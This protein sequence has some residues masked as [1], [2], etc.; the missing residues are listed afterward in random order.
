MQKFEK[1][2]EIVTPTLEDMGY[3]LVR[4]TLGGREA[5]KV[6]QI[7][8]ER[9]DMVPMTVDDCA[10]ISRNLS[11]ILDVED[12]IS[13][14]YALEISSPGLDRPLV[15]VSDFV[16][17]KGFDAKIETEVSLDGAK[18]FKGKIIDIKD[19]EEITMEL[20]DNKGIVHIPF[21]A[22]LKAR[23]IIT[24][25]LINTVTKSNKGF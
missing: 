8:A 7:M 13:G 20:Y 9:K 23:L 1:L 18:R 11:A 10:E 15:K 2:E 3:D 5:R 14:H 24:D 12:P 19:N 6:L 16:R 21:S 22:V 25:E 4:L 17:F